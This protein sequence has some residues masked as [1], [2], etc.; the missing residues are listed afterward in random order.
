MQFLI[1]ISLVGQEAAMYRMPHGRSKCTDFTEYVNVFLRPHPRSVLTSLIVP[2]RGP[3]LLPAPGPSHRSQT[4]GSGPPTLGSE[5]P[6]TLRRK[7]SCAPPGHSPAPAPTLLH[8]P[9][10]SAALVTETGEAPDPAAEQII[11]LPHKC[12]EAQVFLM[13]LTV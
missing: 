5:F 2:L 7:L 4:Q 9:A 8:Q 1:P 3:S 10:E 11:A 13:I 12:Q 6:G